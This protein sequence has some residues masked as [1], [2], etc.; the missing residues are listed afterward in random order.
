MT[1]KLLTASILFYIVSAI[2]II[3]GVIYSLTPGLLPYHER[4]IGKTIEELDPK[5]VVLAIM[6]LRII[7][8]AFT[9]I[10]VGTIMLT[11]KPLKEGYT[12]ARWT[13]ITVL[14]INLLPAMKV[15]L[16][17][18]KDTP[19]WAIGIMIIL[20]LIGFFLSKSE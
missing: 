11:A 12:W 5:L 15:T 16:T 9:A 6:S 17:V 18:G 4:F 10:G 7:G 3:I 20:S 1:K 8:A 19:W 2:L 14:M 13:I